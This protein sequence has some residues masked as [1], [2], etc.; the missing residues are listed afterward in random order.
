M[1]AHRIPGNIISYCGSGITG[2]HA[3][4]WWSTRASARGSGSSVG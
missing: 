3:S 4:S 2:W 1:S